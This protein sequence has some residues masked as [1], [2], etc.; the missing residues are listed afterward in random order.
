MKF[1]LPAVLLLFSLPA[2][3]DN[4]KETPRGRPIARIFT[5]FHTG[6][7]ASHHERGF[8]L[9][10]SYLGYE[11]RITPELTLTGI[12]DVGQSKQ[13]DDLQR[14]AYFKNMML[15]WRHERMTLSAGLIPTLQFGFQEKFWG[16]RFVH[17]SFQDEYKFGDSADMGVSI[18]YSFNQWLAADA[19][20]ANGEGYKKV[21]FNEGLLY[22]AGLTLNPVQGLF[23]RLYG[24]FN[25]EAGEQQLDIQNY[26]AFAGYRNATFSAGAEYNLKKES[27]GNEESQLQ[28][29]SLYSTT[30]LNKRLRLFG[31]FDQLFTSKSKRQDEMKAILGLEITLNSYIKLAPTFTYTQLK[32]N[33]KPGFLAGLYCYFGF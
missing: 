9:S 1:I 11:F 12:L 6:F 4:E 18:S 28:G 16:M 30:A 7:G 31:R 23:F 26:S 20:V 10:R 2:H 17:K 13:V 3:A 8:E 5:N 32:S 27:S 24:S 33:D 14:L 22:G 15:Q 19:I 25:Q 29:Y 21:Q